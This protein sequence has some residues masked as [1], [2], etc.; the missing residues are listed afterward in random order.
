MTNHILNSKR[1]SNPLIFQLWMLQYSGQ[2]PQIF[3][4][5]LS[6]SQSYLKG[7]KKNLIIEKELFNSLVGK[8]VYWKRII[9]KNYWKLSRIW[10][11]LVIKTCFIGSHKQKKI[12]FQIFFIEMTFI[13]WSTNKYWCFNDNDAEGQG[14]VW[15]K[16][17]W[18]KLCFFSWSKV[19]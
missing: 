13:M 14:V 19:S 1:T 4:W 9:K 5:N 18:S 6:L 17:T 16:F 15:P 10:I 12:D 7:N 3:S 8:K 2:N 11:H